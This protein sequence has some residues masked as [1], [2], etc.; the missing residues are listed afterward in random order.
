MSVMGAIMYLRCLCT[1]AILLFESMNVLIIAGLLAE[2]AN[3]KQNAKYRF[4]WKRGTLE[5]IK[6]YCYICKKMGYKWL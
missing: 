6:M 1:L 2:L 4:D 3:V 5:N